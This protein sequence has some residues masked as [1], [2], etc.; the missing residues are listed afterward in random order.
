M[1]CLE[2]PK[3]PA[4]PDWKI[5]LFFSMVLGWFSLQISFSVSHLPC[6]FCIKGFSCIRL[7]LPVTLLLFND[8]QVYILQDQVS[9]HTR[10]MYTPDCRSATHLSECTFVVLTNTLPLSSA[11]IDI[12]HLSFRIIFFLYLVL[13]SVYCQA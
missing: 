8:Q 3:T 2:T 7:C 6:S 9:S 13:H 11:V 1:G 10:K 12:R 4:I 5:N